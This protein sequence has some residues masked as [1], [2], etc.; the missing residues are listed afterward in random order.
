MIAAITRKSATR[1]CGVIAFPV[2]ERYGIEIEEWMSALSTDRPSIRSVTRVVKQMRVGLAE[3]ERVKGSVR[4]S[5]LAG[6]FRHIIS[7]LEA[8]EWDGARYLLLTSLAVMSARPMASG[9]VQTFTVI[10][11][12]PRRANAVDIAE[13]SAG[14]V[15]GS[16]A[17]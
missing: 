9:K 7:S 15:I 6:F 2:F 8:S 10:R 12:F 17:G 3:L 14:P 5:N 13:L 11:Q 1:K 16:V 4:H